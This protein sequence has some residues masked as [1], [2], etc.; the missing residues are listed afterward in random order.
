MLRF[1]LA[2]LYDK[3]GFK[4]LANQ[5]YSEAEFLAKAKPEP[6]MAKYQFSS[7]AGAW[8]VFD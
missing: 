3:I 2:E 1:V 5:E 4:T 7:S 6:S 8:T